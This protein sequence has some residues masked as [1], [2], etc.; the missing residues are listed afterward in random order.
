MQRLI[1]ARRN[2]IRNLMKQQRTRYQ[3]VRQRAQMRLQPPPADSKAQSWN[4]SDHLRRW[5]ES[6]IPPQCLLRIL[7]VP[8]IRSGS[9]TCRQQ[10]FFL[11]G[12]LGLKASPSPRQSP[13]RVINTLL[14]VQLTVT[15]LGLA[16]KRCTCSRSSV[17]RPTSSKVV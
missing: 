10:R 5:P 6:C 12:C 9:A 8:C 14:C 13:F 3:S 7:S 4:R 17:S 1:R 15:R 11:R 2:Q 16:G